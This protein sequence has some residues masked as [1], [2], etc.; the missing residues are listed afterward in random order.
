MN[1][2]PN[3]PKPTDRFTVSPITPD[4]HCQTAMRT[5]IRPLTNLKSICILF[6]SVISVLGQIKNAQTTAK[7]KF[8]HH[9]EII[10]DYDKSKDQ[11]AVVLQWYTVDWLSGEDLYQR[12]T[13]VEKEQYVL[14]I[15][16][17]FSFPGRV[18]KATPQ[19][20]QFEIRTKHPGNAYFKA[21][22]MPELIAVIDGQQISLGR[23]ALVRTNTQVDKDAGQLSYEQ[24]SAYFTYAGLL[25]V[26]AARRVTMKAGE[27]QF[28]LQERHLEA[29][30]DLASRMSP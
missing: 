18:I 25:R 27:L 24:V 4:D 20:V 21:G 8:K 3:Q 26:I 17:A 5:I 9:A 11:T 2:A 28:D 13:A 10:S 19:T 30:R 15:Q 7:P 16:A 23:T 12:R 14:R 1:S 6:V 29:L 22:A